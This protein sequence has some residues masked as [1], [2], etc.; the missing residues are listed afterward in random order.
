[1][2]FDSN[3][4][5]IFKCVEN[6]H[7]IYHIPKVL[8]HRKVNESKNVENEECQSIVNHYRRTGITFISGITEVYYRA[9][10]SCKEL[11]SFCGADNA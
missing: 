8:Y 11:W 7:N 2:D 10:C 5:Y 9:D 1:M 4:D 6:S 3:Y